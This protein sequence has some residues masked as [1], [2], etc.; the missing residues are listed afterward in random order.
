ML[1]DDVPV[2]NGRSIGR[3]DLPNGLY[4]AAPPHSSAAAAFSYRAAA[5]AAAA[6]DTGIGEVDAEEAE[7][8]ATASPQY[9][10]VLNTG[11]YDPSVRS[12]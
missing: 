5:A 3:A 6:A 10:R 7:G 9:R 1:D 11:G 8:P 4:Q 12:F 2:W